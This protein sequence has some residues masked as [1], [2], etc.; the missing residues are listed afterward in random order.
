MMVAKPGVA[1]LPASMQ[2]MSLSDLPDPIPSFL[3]AVQAG[4][5]AALRGTLDD[6]AVL[7]D[8]DR[9]YSCDAASVWLAGL[10]GRG[11]KAMRAI[12]EA[13]QKSEI[14]MTVLTIEADAGGHDMEMLQDWHF[15]VRAGRIASVQIAPRANLI[16]PPVVAT[17]VRAANFMDLEVLLA[18]FA[19]DALVNDQLCDHRGEQAIRKW[20]AREILG[21]RL[22]IH[23]VEVIEHRSHVVVTANI[24][25]DFD[26]RG[27][28][29]PLVL[30]F[31]FS[32]LGDQIEQLIILQNQ[33]RT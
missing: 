8:D 11:I 29:D 7:T 27:L 25:G 33:P 13:K 28:P 9:D 30:T 32:L 15:T 16:L 1:S 17:F 22:T 6:G 26:R 14:V 12:N 5:G 18:T 24:N 21:E 4:D 19:D 23:V 10:S 3:R 31:Y 2:A 20:A